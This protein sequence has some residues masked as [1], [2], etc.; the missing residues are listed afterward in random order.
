M[1]GT[2]IENLATKP[3]TGRPTVAKELIEKVSNRKT[4]PMEEISLK[5]HSSEGKEE[6]VGTEKA[7]AE[8]EKG[9]KEIDQTRKSRRSSK[10]PLLER[11]LSPGRRSRRSKKDKAKSESETTEI[12]DEVSKKSDESTKSKALSASPTASSDNAKTPKKHDDTSKSDVKEEN[13]SLMKGGPEK[14]EIPVSP[15]ELETKASTAQVVNESLRAA[16]GPFD[17]FK[18]GKKSK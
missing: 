10:S 1:S 7:E 12:S 2:G 15:S 4:S 17:V 16:S 9:G 6:S 18:F 5:E 13:A 3:P 14:S 8:V 11:L